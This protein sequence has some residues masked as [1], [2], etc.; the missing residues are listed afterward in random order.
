MNT[1]SAA[2]HQLDRIDVDPLDRIAVAQARA[3][4][5]AE[6]QVATSVERCDECTRT[7]AALAITRLVE[8]TSPEDLLAFLSPFDPLPRA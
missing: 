1:V 4:E 5:G 3:C 8:S 2:L 6:T 7:L